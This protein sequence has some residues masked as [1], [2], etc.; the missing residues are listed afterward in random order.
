MKIND[1]ARRILWFSNTPGSGQHYLD[2]K[3]YGE[4]W[5]SSLQTEVENNPACKLGFAF[6]NDED[7]E[8]FEFNRTS[9]FPVRRLAS[10]K[11]KRLL[12]RFIGKTEKDENVQNFLR[13][14]ERFEPDLIHIQGTENPFG[15]IQNHITHIPIVTS[16]QGNLTAYASKYFSGMKMPGLFRQIRAGY[17]YPIQDFRLFVRRS[18]TEREILQKSRYVFGRTDWDRRICRV[19]APQARYFKL[20]EMLRP[21]FYQARWRPPDNPAPIF[22]TTSSASFYKGFETL[23]QTAR[24]LVKNGVRFAWQV[25][26]LTAKDPLVKLITREQGVRD[27]EELNIRLLGRLSESELVK[28]MT[29]ADMYIQVS[30]IENS[31]NSLCEAMLLGMPILATYAG[32]TS[33]LLEDKCTGT[34]VQDGDP[35]ALAGG[36]LEGV[37]SP[38]SLL[39]MAGEAY[40]VSHKRHDRPEIVSRLLQVYE[41]IIAFHQ[42]SGA[43]A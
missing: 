3:V 2:K 25:A 42:S 24:L 1:K 15:L 13:I 6:Y 28:R 20:E 7:L 33:S 30:H 10:T 41:E 19:M 31:P 43:P 26:G 37:N 21:G 23:I 34:L 22:F 35:F 12:Y 27:L 16:I 9:Y 8:P 5:I 17:P 14:A 18:E 38:R 36:I 11:N 29:A 4:G 32:G 39:K 40:E